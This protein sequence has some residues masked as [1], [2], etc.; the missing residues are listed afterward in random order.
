[1][2]SKNRR[3]CRDNKIRI[4]RYG[5]PTHLF[6]I[7]HCD[8]ANESSNVDEQVEI[9]ITR[10]NCMITRPSR[11]SHTKYTLAIVME[12][13]TITL[14]PLFSVRMNSLVRLYCSATS[15]EMFDLNRPVPGREDIKVS[16]ILSRQCVI[17]AAHR[18]P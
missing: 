13:S 17:A 14:S 5:K 16:P 7:C 6:S 2:A 4:R 9:L 10:I 11:R 8:L 15:G 18:N 1:M 12:G 3:L